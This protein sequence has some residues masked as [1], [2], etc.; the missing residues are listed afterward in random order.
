[1]RQISN[2]SFPNDSLIIISSL[3]TTVYSP[4][5]TVIQENTH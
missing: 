5:N 3:S 2:E 4:E 1:M